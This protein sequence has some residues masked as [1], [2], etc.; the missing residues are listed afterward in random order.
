MYTRVMLFEAF[1]RM[2]MDFLNGPLNCDLPL[3]ATFIAALA[4][5]AMGCSGYLGTV[6]PQE[7]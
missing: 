6:Q 3:K 1:E 2:V 5:G 4:P 7:P